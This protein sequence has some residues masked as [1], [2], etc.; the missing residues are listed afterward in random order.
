[1]ENQYSE[2]KITVKETGNR[3]NYSFSNNINDIK[4]AI[5]NR[6]RHDVEL[7]AVIPKTNPQ[8]SLCVKELINKHDVEFLMT[9]FIN[10]G[11]N[12]VVINRRVNNNWYSVF[13]S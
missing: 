8:L 3:Y 1:M 11:N 4:K 12:S 7:N 9:T 13:F 10:S 6:K 5:Y 2:E